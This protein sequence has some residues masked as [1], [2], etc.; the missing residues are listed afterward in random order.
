MRD[1]YAAIAATLSALGGAA[2]L[3][4]LSIVTVGACLALAYGLALLIQFAA[5]T[6]A[7]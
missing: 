2:A 6:V 1:L 4:V 5:L 3:T 7:P